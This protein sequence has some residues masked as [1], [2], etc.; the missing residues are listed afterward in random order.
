MAST[1]TQELTSQ[2]D[3]VCIPMHG[4]ARDHDDLLDTVG[5]RSIVMLGEATHAT[6]EFTVR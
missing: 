6:H 2:I 5:D 1:S 3:R 4:G